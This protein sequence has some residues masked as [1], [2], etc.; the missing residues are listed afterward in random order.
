[1]A[2]WHVASVSDGWRIA[3]TEESIGEGRVIL[4]TPAGGL[5]VTGRIDRIDRH[6]DTGQWRVIDYKTSN[7]ANPPEK[8]HRRGTKNDRAWINLQLP[9]YRRLVREALGVDG[10]VQLGFLALP[11]KLDDTKFLP[12]EWSD[13]ELLE[14]DTVI[15]QVAESIVRGEFDRIAS[16]P[17]AFSDDWARICQDHLPHLP[18]HE[19]WSQP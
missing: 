3:Y 9:L 18:R 12:A 11:T 16:K 1:F 14:A 19:H 13:E 6:E 5:S 15:N 17:P 7:A 2:A 10:D 4:D 8:V